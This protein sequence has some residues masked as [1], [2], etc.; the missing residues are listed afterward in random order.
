MA[1]M[2]KLGI[3]NRESKIVF[4][5][6][7]FDI[8]HYGHIEFFK[9]V[10]ALVGK[11]GKFIVAVHDDDSVKQ[12]KGMLRPVNTQ[13]HRIKVLKAIKYIDEVLLWEGWENIVELVRELRPDYIAVI[14]GDYESKSLSKVANELEIEVVEIGKVEGISTSV[15]ISRMTKDK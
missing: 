7:V 13:K 14:K 12:K 11:Q 6:G 4:A 2:N 8:L 10:K 15:I 3:K 1:I 5:S 9:K